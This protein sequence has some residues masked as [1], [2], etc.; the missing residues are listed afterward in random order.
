MHPER[1]RRIKEVL[2]VSLRLAPAERPEYLARVCADDSDLRE[3][4]DSLIE[5][6]EEA[7]DE[8]E[9]APAA[10]RDPLLGAMLG[11]YRLVDLIGSGGMGSVYRAERADDA[12]R[13][14]VAIKV[15]RSGLDR[16]LMARHF[17][18][19]RQIMASLEHPNIA[20]LLDGGATADGA[21]YFV[22][23]FIRG[24]PVD[25]YCLDLKLGVR[26]R[27]EL[28]GAIC[29]AVGFAHGLGVVHRDIKPWNILVTAEGAPKLLDFGIAKIVHPD[30]AKDGPITVA[31][32][33]TP[34]YASPEQQ[35]GDAV[36]AASDVYSLGVL[37]CELLTGKRPCD[38]SVPPGLPRDL[39]TIVRMATREEPERRYAS[40]G[41]FGDD[42][43]RYLDGL[44]VRARK[45]AF[46]YRA[47]KFLRRQRSVALAVASGLAAPAL[48]YVAIQAH[49]RWRESSAPM[50][51]V[52]LTSAPGREFQP[53]FSPDGKRVVYS[54]SGE[55]G[56]NIDVYWQTIG[57]S[58]PVRLTTDKAQDLSPAWSP[59]GAQIAWLRTGP[60]E[61]A[62][63]VAPAV[64]GTHAKVADLFPTRVE[65]VGRHLDW[66]PDGKSLA[67][68]DKDAPGLPFRIVFID[69]AT[70]RKRQATMPP[71]N[72]IG[73]MAPC[74][75]P[76]G[77]WLAFLRAVSSG[78]G[79]VWVAPVA[80]GEPRRV[81]TDNRSILAMTWGPDGR[82]IVFSS[83]RMRNH[84]LWRIPVSGGNPTR[85]PMV[86]ENASEPAFSRDGRRMVYAQLFED[87]NIWRFDLDGRAAPRKVV[88][89]TQY[90][91]S[92]TIAPDGARIA[93]RSSRSGSNEIWQSDANGR[94]A[95]QFTHVGGALTGSP[96]WSPDGRWIA[97]DSRP[98]GQADIYVMPAAGGAMRRV[99]NS[100]AEDVVPSWSHDGEWIYFASIR[101]GAWQV[102][103]ARAA[104][105]GPEEQVTRQGGFASQE[106]AD[107]KYLYYA[108]GRSTEGLWR[109]RLP[110]GPEEP[111]VP[112]LATGF[113]GYWTLAKTGAYFLDWSGPGN[114][115][116]LWFQ[117]FA[118]GRKAIGK[119]EGPP[120][121]ADAGF[122]ISPDGKYILFSQMDQSGSDI[123]VL[124]H[125]RD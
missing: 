68:S 23:E 112:G 90:D 31:P 69:V 94:A 18:L 89:S 30:G 120:V 73:D 118:G 96:K 64:N 76:D 24:V 71:E 7:G 42:I 103:R 82:S 61:T 53:S 29:A 38:G 41:A 91:S 2:D 33:M 70:G 80:G 106:S 27:L 113:W 97:F 10:P 119:I 81:T 37:L 75:S 46:G 54:A 78:V 6:Y 85:V 125:Y 57:G 1:W 26:E 36:T 109:K 52:T 115:A 105:G 65:S 22:M 44:P 51:I 62:I 66:S 104:G 56:E 40:A 9:T 102:W 59:D 50:Q 11:P 98:D 95:W 32:A 4:V 43:R 60:Q 93:F 13:K 124:E 79:D 110:D 67:A 101:S 21:P 14:E 28:F 117:S 8:L 39:E 3:E 83:N 122:T 48:V 88:S 74:F 114:P 116:N 35:R 55:S 84:A 107:G 100:P 86:S 49:D 92:P 123:L 63:F 25:R 5:A 121:V 58:Q 108:K 77:K 17:R 87:T 15:V 111:F 19:E 45:G 34:A 99:S 20:R 12:Y 72:I 47:S 16:N